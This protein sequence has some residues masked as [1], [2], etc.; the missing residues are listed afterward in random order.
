MRLRTNSL[1]SEDLQRMTEFSKWILDLGD[2][3]L[4][5]IANEDE[6]EASSIRIPD[7]LT[8]RCDND[9]ITEIINVVYPQLLDHYKEEVYLREREQYYVQQMIVPMKLII[10]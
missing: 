5:T 8:I 2:G 4:P 1:H 9:P 3:M 6:D 10:T 7:D